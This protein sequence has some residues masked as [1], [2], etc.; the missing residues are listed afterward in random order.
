MAMNFFKL[1]KPRKFDFKPRYYDPVKEEQL[2]R[3]IRIREEL[4]MVEVKPGEVDPATYRAHIK[5]QFRK[6]M[7][8]DSRTTA[9]ARRQS[10]RR[11]FIIMAILMLIFYFLFY[12]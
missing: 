4:G 2:E 9:E 11:L 6:V 12:R 1:S 5:G 10:N 7:K 8:R 3:E